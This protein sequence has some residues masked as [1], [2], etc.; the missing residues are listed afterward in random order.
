[1]IFQAGHVISFN[2]SKSI[3]LNKFRSDRR[4]RTDDQT[5]EKEE[6]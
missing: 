5:N 1:M 4:Y 2:I 3:S 6:V